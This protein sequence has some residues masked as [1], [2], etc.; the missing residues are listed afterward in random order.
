MA[1]AGYDDM[2]F[3]ESPGALQP[4]ADNHG[5]SQPPR[6]WSLPPG[7]PP[8]PPGASAKLRKGRFA[9]WHLE[10]PLVAEEEG[11]LL[12]Y[13]DVITLLLVML[14][15]AGSGPHGL[16]A[17]G[18]A[19]TGNL[20]ATAAVPVIGIPG[21]ATPIPLPVPMPPASSD[22]APEPDIAPE[23]ELLASL[24]PDSLDKNIEVIVNKGSVSFRISSEVLFNSGEATLSEAGRGVMS[25][26]VPALGKAPGYRVVVEGHTDNMPIQTE[27]FPSNWELSTGRA[28][29]VVRH[30]QGQGIA[31]ARMRA[32]GYADTRP[33]ASNDTA[34]GRATNRH[35]E[36]ILETSR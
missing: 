9:R 5:S 36:V 32:T 1:T 25:R 19:G 35:V 17:N 23:L 8:R 3:H 20:P 12:T 2:A 18:P 14:A 11:W 33:I 31:A 29:S 10:P 34:Q 30:F 26:L 28:A 13:L 21:S 16:P 7:V 6:S 24:A 22:T 15:F 27:R 4:G